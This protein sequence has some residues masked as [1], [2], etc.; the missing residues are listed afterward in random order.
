MPDFG[1]RIN[2]VR[3]VLVSE[4]ELW[5]SVT[6]AVLRILNQLNLSLILKRHTHCKFTKFHFFCYDLFMSDNKMTNKVVLG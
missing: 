4:N 6:A 5:I 1:I 3:P 2:R